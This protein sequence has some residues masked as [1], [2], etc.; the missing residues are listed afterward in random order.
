M[1][2][3][4]AGPLFLFKPLGSDFFNE[5]RDIAQNMQ[6]I[7]DWAVS[8]DNHVNNVL[9]FTHPVAIANVLDGFLSAADKN[10]IDGIQIGAINQTTADARYLGLHASSDN[11]LA[12]GGF[13]AN[14]YPRLGVTNTFTAEQVF[15]TVYTTLNAPSGQSASLRFKINGTE[16]WQ[17]YTD[18]TSGEMR[19]Y[20]SVAM[21]TRIQFKTDGKVNAPTGLQEAGTD[22]S[23]KY[24][25]ISAKAADAEKLDG[26]D[27]SAFLKLAGGTMIGN[28]HM[29]ENTAITVDDTNDRLAF[30]KQSG[31]APEIRY[32]SSAINIKLVTA[33]T[34]IA[35]TTA[36]TL[37]TW[38]VDNVVTFTNTPLVGSTA[39]SLVGHVHSGADITT[40]TIP[41]G[42]FPATL[43]A[44]SGAN[45]TALNAS[46]LGS[47][48]VPVARLPLATTGAAGVI[49]VGSNLTISSGVLSLASGNVTSALGYTPVN[50]AGDTGVGSFTWNGTGNFKLGTILA[51]T[52]SVGLIFR[53]DGVRHAGLSWNG[54]ALKVINAS[55]SAADSDLWDTNYTSLATF[56][57]LNNRVL[58]GIE[59]DDGSNMLQV[60][61]K[62]L[63]HDDLTVAGG[64]INLTNSSSN[65]VFFNAN[66]VDYPTFTARS[67]GTKIVLNPGVSATT[68]DFAL[69]IASGTL[70]NSVPQNTNAY[71]FRW[72]GGTTQ[73]M[74]LDGTGL[75]SVTGN[76]QE[77]GTLLSDKYLGINANAGS[78]TKLQ[79]ARTI[80]IS[81]DG[82]ATGTFDGTGNLDLALAITDDSHWHT[83]LKTIDD[84][85]MKPNV[86]TY[87][88]VRAYFTSKEG[89]TGTAGSDYQDLLVLNTYTDTSGGKMNALAFDK[90]SQL[91]VHYQAAQADTTWGTPK[92]LAYTDSSITGNSATATKLATSRTISLTG[93]ITGSGTFDGSEDLSI[94]TTVN[95]TH[96]YLPLAGGTLTGGLTGTTGTFSGAL[97]ATAISLSQ[98][99]G[100]T[101]F[102]TL[103]S[104]V[105]MSWVAA[106]QL[107]MR[108]L[109]QLR[110][111]SDNTWDYNNWAGIKY[112][113]TGTLLSIGGPG[114]TSPFTKNTADVAANIDFN[115]AAELRINTVKFLDSNRA[116]DFT[117]L[118]IDGS[119]MLDLVTNSP[120]IGP[121]NPFWY[122]LRQGKK[123]FI[124]EE[125]ATGYNT[126]ANYAL[127]TGSTFTRI[128]MVGAPNNTGKV[129]EIKLAAASSPGF[130][131]FAQC[132]TSRANATFVQVFKA[133]LPTGYWFYDAQNGQGTNS[134]IYWLTDRTGTGKWETYI[135]VALCGD[136]GTF[137]TGGH[138]YINGSPTPTAG[139][140]VYCYVASCTAYD[141]TDLGIQ[142]ADKLYT[143]RTISLTGDVTGSGSFDGSTNLSITATVADDSHNHTAST[144]TA[145]DNTNGAG[146]IFSNSNTVGA[147]ITLKPSTSVVTNGA[148]GWSLYAAG[149]G[150]AI[151]DGNVG[152]W[153]HGTNQ[154]RLR[155]FRDGSGLDIMSG[156]LYLNN[157]LALSS[158]GEFI[159]PAGTK[160]YQATYN[161]TNYGILKH[162]NN[163]NITVNA[164]TGYLLLGYENTTDIYVERPLT[165]RPTGDGVVK[166]TWDT[167]GLL[168]AKGGLQVNGVD[169]L[170]K[171]GGTLTGGLTGTTATFTD[172]LVS[173]ATKSGGI[174]N[175]AYQSAA[176][177]GPSYVGNWNGTNLWGIGNNGASTVQIGEVNGSTYAWATGTCDLNLLN[178]AL[179][180]A[181]NTAI[182]ASRNF[183]GAAATF[184]G[185]VTTPKLISCSHEILNGSDTWLR[186]KDATGWY[187]TTYS[188][189]IYMDDTTWVKVYNSKGFLVSN[190]TQ[191]NNFQTVNT[192]GA[193]YKFWTSESFKIYMS[194]A[195]NATW[196]GE[197]DT[198]A[199]ID[200]NMYF[201]MTSYLRGFVWKGPLT[202]GATPTPLMHL[203]GNGLHTAVPIKSAGTVSAPEVEIKS[204]ATTKK[205]RIEYNETED[206]LDFV[207]SDS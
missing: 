69:G 170:L 7:N 68:V 178:G 78:A 105:T 141:L 56:D 60:G 143:A 192:D 134:T 20:D 111:S 66:G 49:Q 174:V 155:V 124:D 79:T 149:P 98:A 24:L 47:G 67:A 157:V 188:G 28:L 110:F 201:L 126:V 144:S 165:F 162:H 130:G 147:G 33:G 177:G 108:N 4:T 87:G 159:L 57:I 181:G 97:S 145:W 46:N 53:Q 63:F 88:S 99:A 86:G 32:R 34:L 190:T 197:I 206:C 21:T 36:S 73:V 114:G 9:G 166:G 80:S 106:N 156:G 184:T 191:S 172:I 101:P 121:L 8:V 100:S 13:A 3:Q 71:H 54:T 40:G 15:N 183:T 62:G 6:T 112:N 23:A 169:V 17:W 41:D 153:A 74:D 115:N 205:F 22:L 122:A 142:Y 154:A 151:G 182:D 93:A 84:R 1:P 29:A 176:G 82:T 2:L 148:Y 186:T 12:L 42:R 50:K 125:F 158:A 64:D 109:G 129:L 202:N 103:P 119:K 127:G 107:V 180:I 38:G 55:N 199:N 83:T 198:D 91:I 160:S 150:G 51:G 171:S 77:A 45:L 65:R 140:P 193:G 96:S 163:G 95:H 123:L 5:Q 76:I 10:K 189:G 37:M 75:L 18:G 27:S 14:T 102:V 26:Y 135:R 139:A 19:L 133:K 146:F 204:T 52:S 128:D 185:S 85:D 39:I 16:K 167:T 30:V 117:V 132:W 90:S 43:P 138:V 44:L 61:G 59:T 104:G 70:W 72:Y 11:S 131:G 89:L 175:R 118:S 161:S 81:G 137:S 25:G 136:S 152:L 196:G 31:Y 94:A 195:A 113:P 116:A 164:A 48:T 35:P 92:T 187:N 194:T 203:T 168:N 179:K 207:F 200:Y 58:I 173:Q 120:A